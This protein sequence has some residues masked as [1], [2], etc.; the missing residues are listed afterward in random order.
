MLGWA[1]KYKAREDLV[2]L[3][4]DAGA[5]VNL[6]YEV[7]WLFRK[8]RH[9]IDLAATRANVAIFK[10]LLNSG[11][12]IDPIKNA[13]WDN[14]PDNW[15]IVALAVIEA[16][17]VEI[18]KEVLSRL[19]KTAFVD[20]E[21]NTLLHYAVGCATDRA[22]FIKELIDFGFDADASAV[23]LNRSVHHKKNEIIP[24]PLISS[25]S[26]HIGLNRHYLSGPTHINNIKALLEK[27]ADV[28]IK[29]SEGMT[30]L[31]ILS[32]SFQEGYSQDYIEK[33]ELL[34]R[35]GS[36][37][38]LRDNQ[39]HTPL[40]LAALNGL[41]AIVSHLI[42]SGARTKIKSSTGQTP[43][44]SA[45]E[46]TIDEG[47]IPHS[48]VNYFETIDAF[49]ESGLWIDKNLFLK[50][51]SGLVQK[52]KKKINEASAEQIKVLTHSR[53]FKILNETYL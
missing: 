26:G 42:K 6:E 2:Q 39:G 4:I 29:N 49:S 14:D 22:A 32:E 13:K 33:I 27:G 28:N 53:T 34:R 36:S 16:Q 18:L 51:K 38:E 10:L 23:R 41:P 47:S 17:D 52:L 25:L 24:P 5:D 15:N 44:E 45:L 37:I 7:G 40:H 48:I 46:R 21:G 35:F 8:K 3:I 20:V 12:K 50:H 11:A 30:A 19:D 9:I 43:L 1:I 31:H